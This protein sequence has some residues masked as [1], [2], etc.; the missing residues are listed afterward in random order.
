MSMPASGENA[1]LTAG[2]YPPPSESINSKSPVFSKSW[3]LNFFP[4]NAR[5]LLAFQ[6]LLDS[7]SHCPHLTRPMI[8]GHGR[9]NPIISRVGDYRFLTLELEEFR[10]VFLAKIS[11]RTTYTNLASSKATNPGLTYT[12]LASSKATNPG[13]L[14]MT[15]FGCILKG[16]DSKGNTN[17][18]QIVL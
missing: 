14:I 16:R 11:G 9:H 1:Q 8:Y 3:K 10:K 7:S 6:I 18:P 13:L 12:N 15:C 4:S 2:I 5:D 17:S